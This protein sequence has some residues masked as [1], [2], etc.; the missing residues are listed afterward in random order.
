MLWIQGTAPLPSC[1]IDLAVYTSRVDTRAVYVYDVF[2]TPQT[3]L[4]H[5]RTSQ[6]LRSVHY[7]R[8]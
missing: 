3:S 8:K 1:M 6:S 7:A 4:K 5:I 2:L